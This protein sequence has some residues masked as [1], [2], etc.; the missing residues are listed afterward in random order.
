MADDGWRPVTDEVI[1]RM[2]EDCARVAN[3]PDGKPWRLPRKQFVE[4][5]ETVAKRNPWDGSPKD[6]GA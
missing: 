6:S 3:G 5:L 2:M 1:D 4:M